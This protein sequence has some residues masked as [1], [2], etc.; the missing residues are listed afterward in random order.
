MRPLELKM[1]DFL[2]YVDETFD[3]TKVSN[4]TVIG[5]NGAGKSSFCTDAITWS[6][7]GKG[8]RGSEKENGNYVRKGASSCC[9]ELTFDIEG[10]TY[11]VIRAV[12]INKNN[13]MALNLFVI[14]ADGVEVPL[15]GGNLGETQ[16]KIESLIKMSYKTF[17]TSSMVFQGKT[18]E[19]TNGMSSSERKD[20]LIDMLNI[21]EWED[22]ESEAKE[23]LNALKQELKDNETKQDNQ[24][25]VIEGKPSY[26]SRKKTAET[27]ISKVGYDKA[28]LEAII[29]K[30]QQAI[31]QRETIV[32]TIKQKQMEVDSLNARVNRNNED[33]RNQQSAVEKNN[34]AIQ[35]NNEQIARYQAVLAQKEEIDE[36]IKQE[37]VLQKELSCL[38]EK[39]R[40]YV[41]AH[42]KLDSIVNAGKV[43][44]VNQTN[45]IKTLTKQIADAEKQAKALS[46]VPCANNDKLTSSCAFLK[47]AVEARD[48]LEELKGKK[49]AREKE[50]N[51]NTDKWKKQREFTKELELKPNELENKQAELRKVQ[52]V[53]Q[54]KAILESAASSIAQLIEGNDDLEKRNADIKTRIMEIR[55]SGTEDKKKLAELE[56]EIVKTNKEVASF[57]DVFNE[58]EQTKKALEQLKQKYAEAYSELGSCDTLL[59]QVETAEIELKELKKK[60]KE[61]AKDIDVTELLVEA[62]GKKSG[63]PALIVE[64]AIPELETEANNILE[65]MMDGRLQIR[66]DTQVETAKGTKKEV[67]QITVLDDG[68][69]RRYETYSG[70]EK[71]SVDL[72]IRIA[73]SKFLCKRSGASVSLFVLDEGVSCAD[74][75]NRDEIV[76]AIRS[77]TNEFDTVLFVTHIEELKDALDQKI[78]VTKSAFNGSHIELV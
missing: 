60:A 37:L 76:K 61:L 4:A 69:E 23:K 25:K 14:N 3:F 29:E 8:S 34:K 16:D 47:M 74:E 32:A 52:S 78:E 28:K 18:D 12:N 35:K 48:S 51:P 73:M 68:E 11:R 43:W 36:A 75:N 24:N 26:E 19:F 17:T 63:V 31:F 13:R 38:F 41:E 56:R 55:E 5:R 66:L 59:K 57:D 64:N 1:K 50:E 2:S 40:Q 15:T 71:F 44:A 42:S 54:K 22:I 30:N 10:T 62:C 20:A 72:A 33:I 27:I 77:V 21:G 58:Q 65:N 53:A 45:D 49:A 67:L 9:V 70:A 39:Q 6:L 7:Y 46:S